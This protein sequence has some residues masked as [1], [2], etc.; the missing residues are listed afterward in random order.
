MNDQIE[1]Y[2]VRLV[3]E[4]IS[5]IRAIKSYIELELRNP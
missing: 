3:D 1:Q 2:D 5:D 4:A